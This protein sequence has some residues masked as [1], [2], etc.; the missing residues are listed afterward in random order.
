MLDE[1]QARRGD[2]KLALANG[3][4][5]EAADVAGTLPVVIGYVRDI[6][7]KQVNPDSLIGRNLADTVEQFAAEMVAKIRA[8]ADEKEGK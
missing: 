2:P 3:Y 7:G 1:M 6:V 4:L 8:A 5:L